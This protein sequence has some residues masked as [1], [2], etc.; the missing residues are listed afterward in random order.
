[1]RFACVPSPVTASLMQPGSP[2]AMHMPQDIGPDVG[3]LAQ[4]Q[5]VETVCKGMPGA[6]QRLGDP[7]TQGGSGGESL[8]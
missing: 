2:L 5:S 6:S 7:Y 3:P 8:Y 1:M 4:T